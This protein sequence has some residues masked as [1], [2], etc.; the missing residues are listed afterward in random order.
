ME[1][2]RE[3]ID[4]HVSAFRS[5]ER[6][7]FE[8][9]DNFFLGNAWA[10][11]TMGD[12]EAALIKTSSNFV[13]PIVETA[14]SVLIPPN[15][16][17]SPDPQRPTPPEVLN[18]VGDLVNHSLH[19]GHYRDELSV[20]VQN[21]VKYGR[22]P[23]KTTW[24]AERDLPVTRFIDPRNYFFDQ[25]AL[26]FDDIRYEIEATLLSKKQMEKRIAQKLYRA[27][28]LSRNSSGVRYP[29]WMTKTPGNTS[30][31]DR[32]RNYTP[33]YLVW[34]VYDRENGRTIHYLDGHDNP[35]L[36]DD[37]IYRPYDLLTFNFNGANVG[38]ISEIGL[39][40][41]NQEEY[42]WTATFLLNI[43]RYG[44]PV[45][46]EDAASSSTDAAQ[47]RALAPVGSRVPVAVPGNKKIQ[48]L[49]MPG[50]LPPYPQLAQDILAK[51]QQNIANVSAINDAQRAQTIGARTATELAFIEGNVK[52]RLRPRQSRVDS[53]TENVAEKH[54]L[55]ASRYMREDKVFKLTGGTKDWITVTPWTVD[56]VECAFRMVPYSPMESNK[57]VMVETLRNIQ[58]LV[59]GNPHVDQRKLTE[60]L[61][62]LMGFEDLLLPEEQVAAMA[63]ASAGGPAAP[64]GAPVQAGPTP[65]VAADPSVADAPSDLPPRS[66]NFSEAVAARPDAG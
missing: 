35:I 28:D 8:K 42:N 62:D 59:V 25:T 22:A 33:W 7:L 24:D 32:L 48:D 19:A 6:K 46:Y 13:F 55:L 15:P 50:P 21:V 30:N 34:E 45:I 52:N 61:F 66:A 23:V 20:A 3:I 37:L 43:L 53:L 65:G 64:V 16:Q 10:N 29:E 1:P 38:G 31:I 36:E 11:T 41:S 60:K 17:V 47:K 27:V 58:P 26:R 44:V 40:L 18:A 9:V 14:T 12:S 51:M 54:L 56:G 63:Q 39:I 4:Y 49:F 5:G 57:A 2:W